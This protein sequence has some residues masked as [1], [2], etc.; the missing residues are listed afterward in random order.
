MPF[1]DD[2]AL[3]LGSLILVTGVTGYLASV[4]ADEFVKRGYRAS[5]IPSSTAEGFE[6]TV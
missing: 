4:S 1:P 6:G 2:V 3:P 5:L